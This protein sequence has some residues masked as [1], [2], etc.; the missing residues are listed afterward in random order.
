MMNVL[1]VCEG[2]LKNNRGLWKRSWQLE[3]PENSLG[4]YEVRLTQTEDGEVQLTWE[5]PSLAGRSWEALERRRR[6]TDAGG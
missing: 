3:V 5:L 4:Y 1:I 6:A 2:N